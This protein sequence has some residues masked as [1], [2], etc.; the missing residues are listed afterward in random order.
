[1]YKIELA[2]PVMSF[3]LKFER[4]AD[5]DALCNSLW[6]DSISL[7]SAF[8]SFYLNYIGK[9]PGEGHPQL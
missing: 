8:T 9:W 7:K 6:R 4:S 5:P 2:V 3:I 1:M